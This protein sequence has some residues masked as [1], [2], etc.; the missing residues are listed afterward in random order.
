MKKLLFF[1]FSAGILASCLDD[2]YTQ[3]NLMENGIEIFNIVN[4][5]QDYTMDPV[6]LAFR[7]NILLNEAAAA[8]TPGDFSHITYEKEDDTRVLMQEYLL[9]SLASVS[10]TSEGVWEL[11]FEGNGVNGARTGKVVINTGGLMLEELYGTGQQWYISL[12]EGSSIKYDFSRNGDERV[13]TWL[14][15]TFSIAPG[16]IENN[17]TVY[18]SDYVCSYNKL[19]HS[20]RWG[21]KFTITRVGA[22]P[23]SLRNTRASTFQFRGEAEGIPYYSTLSMSYEAK[24]LVYK[25]SCSENYISSGSAVASFLER[26]EL[27]ESDYP[28]LTT[29][30]QWI[31]GETEC[32]NNIM[33]T[34]NGNSMYIR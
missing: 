6:S 11:V 5:Q 15:G 34:Y 14:N 24:E 31:S 17:W 9:S 4:N 33:M 28:S 12:P 19:N 22:L 16:I 29:V 23:A 20:S 8:G 1:L 7:L 25:P 10:Q 32:R 26:G 30:I 2:E 3:P 18:V 21:G 27:S 13:I